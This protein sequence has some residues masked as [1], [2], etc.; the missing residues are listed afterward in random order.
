MISYTAEHD[1]EVVIPKKYV[2]HLPKKPN[3][4]VNIMVK[5]GDGI[6]KYDLFQKFKAT[7][8]YTDKYKT[9]MLES[10]EDLYSADEDEDSTQD[11]LK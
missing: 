3:M 1:T 7:K 5:N 6:R 11:N 10:I 2:T 8:K 4:I 9:G